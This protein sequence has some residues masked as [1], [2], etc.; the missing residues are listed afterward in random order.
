MS[1]I[2]LFDQNDHSFVPT[3]R[4]AERRAQA[5]SRMP[6]AAPAEPARSVLDGA[7]HGATLAISQTSPTNLPLDNGWEVLPLRGRD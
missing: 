2:P 4:T 6:L 1:S 7:E 3:C 5:P